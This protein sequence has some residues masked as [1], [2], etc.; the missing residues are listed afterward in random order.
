MTTE[1]KKFNLWNFKNFRKFQNFEF[2]IEFL[3]GTRQSL[4]LQIE[5]R[6]QQD[7]FNLQITRLKCFFSIDKLAD[8]KYCR[9]LS[10]CP[11][12]YRT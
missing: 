7:T 3:V 11:V 4:E 8:K 12:I 2:L 9:H 6:R 10:D 5:A 1:W